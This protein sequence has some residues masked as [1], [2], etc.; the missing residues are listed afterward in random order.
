MSGGRNRGAASGERS[1]EEGRGVSD[2]VGGGGDLGLVRH[3]G[4]GTQRLSGLSV[5]L[6][7]AAGIGV[8]A[9]EVLVVSSAS[10][11]DTSLSIVGGVVG[12][13]DT[14]V[15]ML[16]VV[17]GVGTGGVANLEAENA[18]THKV[19]PF[20]DLLVT[21]VALPSSG[22]DETTEGVSTEVGAVGVELSSGVI[23]SKVD[24]GLVNETDD[25]D[26]VWGLHVL[27]TLKGT[28]GDETS[29]VAGLG[30]PR[31]FL[32]FCLADGGGTR[33]GSPKAEVID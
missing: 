5:G 17:G 19:V 20:D 32:L 31:D 29:A 30:A 24:S 33:R 15:D 23:S 6:D 28:C 1:V 7:L 25:L 12:A 11:E 2:A 21:V 14:I 9:G 16:T 22:V 10:L 4:N 13:S 3:G 18:T 27:D 8:N 26:V